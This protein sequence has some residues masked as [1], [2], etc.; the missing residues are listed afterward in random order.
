MNK[1][2]NMVALQAVA[3][4]L[5]DM[6]PEIVFVGGVTIG[7]YG[8]QKTAPESRPTD[9]VDCIVELASYGDFT[10]LEEEL[11]RRGFRNDAESGIQVRCFG[12]NML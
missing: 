1:H 12:K 8:D 10:R 5:G 3:N 4:A 9:D 2:Q 6:L 11:R 7:L